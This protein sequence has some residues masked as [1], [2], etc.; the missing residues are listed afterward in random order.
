[1]VPWQQILFWSYFG[2]LSILAVYGAHRYVLVYLYYRHRDQRPRPQSTWDEL[3]AVTVQLPVFNEATVVER[4]LD[5]VARI[6]YPRDRFQVQLLDDSVDETRELARAKVEAL[7]ATGLNIEYRHRTDRTGFKAGALE[8]GLATAEGQFVAIFDADFV[9]HPNVLRNT[10]EYFTDPGVGMVQVRWGH[11]NRDYSL[12]TKL[13]SMFLDGH[14]VIEHTARNRSGRH[15]N[16]NGTA[17]I[18]RREAIASAGGWQHDTLTEDLDLSYRAQLHGWRFV[19]LVDEI[20]PAELPVEMSAFKTQQHRWAKGSI[21]TSRKLLPAI[22]GSDSPLKVKL[23]ATFHL[24]AN[25][26]Y[27]LLLL[28]CL[29]MLPALQFRLRDETVWRNVLFD[30]SI[31][32]LA[33]LS[34]VSF[35]VVAQREIDRGWRRSLKYLPGLM[36]LGV[37]LAVN[38]ARAVFE[39]L[40][41]H[42]T[43]FVRTPKYAVRDDLHAPPK[44]RY[45][46]LA[47]WMTGVE[48]AFGSYILLILVTAVR[49][50]LW[51]MSV[52]LLIFAGG[53]FYV[54]F[55]SLWPNWFARVTLPAGRAG[56]P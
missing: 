34:V 1:M 33:T 40:F 26:A 55:A 11:L 31:F 24:T 43:P 35:Y 23:E 37:G 18:W 39:A 49:H 8:A 19:Y 22:W 44:K 50:H 52:F 48:I 16:F 42:D 46:S 20:A 28:M 21:Q 41:S 5:A 2:I 38:N 25:L 17:G 53:F 4:L 10:I 32:V 30:V 54:G 27:P 14:F 56:S 51:L 3:P 12:L 15:F 36:S 29:L 45:R 7:R 9:P 47:G 6:D 13:Q